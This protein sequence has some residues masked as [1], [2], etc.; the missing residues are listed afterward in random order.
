MQKQRSNNIGINNSSK[1]RLRMKTSMSNL[2]LAYLVVV[3]GLLQLVDS[4]CVTYDGCYNKVSKRNMKIGA[5]F[6]DG[7]NTCTCEKS[8]NKIVSFLSTI[9]NKKND[10]LLFR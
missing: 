5:I 4:K 9:F 6:K 7:C 3:F 8:K 1:N 10:I 2:K